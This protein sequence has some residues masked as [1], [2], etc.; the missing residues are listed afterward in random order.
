MIVFGIWSYG[1]HIPKLLLPLLLKIE[2]NMIIFSQ[3]GQT[4][5]DVVFG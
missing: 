1:F 5:C 3:I 4:T 2:K